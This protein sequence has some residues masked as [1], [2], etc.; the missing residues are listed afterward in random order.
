MGN[1]VVKFRGKR[2]DNGDWVVGGYG[3]LGEKT[4]IERHII[5]TTDLDRHATFPQFYFNDIEV[6]PDTVGQFTGLKDRNGAE[7]YEGNIVRWINSDGESVHSVVEFVDGAF[8]V[9]NVCF[10][11]WDYLDN[12]AE[13]IGTIH[14]NPELIGVK[15]EANRHQTSNR[16]ANR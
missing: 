13:I 4:D 9:H 7:I 6:I 1:R 14:D 3:V 16:T 11:L 8:R 12:D 5:L 15:N 2:I 10:T